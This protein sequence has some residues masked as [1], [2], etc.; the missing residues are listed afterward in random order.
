MCFKS[1]LGLNFSNQFDCYF[2][3]SHI[4]YHNCE[5][6]GNKNQTGLNNLRRTRKLGHVI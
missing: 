5:T 4:N 6:K 3:L 1:I 2:S